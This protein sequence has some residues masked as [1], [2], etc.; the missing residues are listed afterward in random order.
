M[1][2]PATRNVGKL[3]NCTILKLPERKYNT[4]A[5]LKTHPHKSD[6]KRQKRQDK[7]RSFSYY[8]TSTCT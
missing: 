3:N 7:N 4:L 2:K 8:R 1:N 5:I 6:L